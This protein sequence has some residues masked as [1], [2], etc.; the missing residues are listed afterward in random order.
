MAKTQCKRA[1]PGYPH[2]HVCKLEAGHPGSMNAENAKRAIHVS[3]KYGKQI[4][5]Q[6]PNLIKKMKQG[7][8]AGKA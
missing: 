5:K 1:W 2:K 7:E 8:N 4:L 3:E 6:P